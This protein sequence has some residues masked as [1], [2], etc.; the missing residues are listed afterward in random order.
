MAL[1]ELKNISKDYHVQKGFFSLKPGT[2]KAVDGVSIDV[3][4]GRTVGIVGESGCGKSTLAKMIVKLIAPTSGEIFFDGKAI[5][6]MPEKEFRVLRKKV[7]IVFQDPSNSLSPRFK[8]SRI[9]SEPLE[10]FKFEKKFIAKRV[11]ELIGEMGLGES[12]LNR[13]PYQLSGGERQRVGIARALATSA[14]LLILD[15]PVSS[16]DLSTQSQ[17]LNLLL[18]LQKDYGLTYLFIAHNLSVIRYISDTIMVMRR[19]NIVEI[20]ESDELYEKP[21]H[22]YTRILLE[23]APSLSKPISKKTFLL[24]TSSVVEADSFGCRF[25][26]RC[27]ARKDKCEK[28]KPQLREISKGH[29]VSCHHAA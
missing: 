13:R 1:L 2:I 17:V 14:K 19:G 27:P 8:I 10:A 15:E 18:K 12:Y 11:K 9:I 24:Q 21:A 4:E 23:S 3:Q 16:L 5:T 6:N 7:Q 25:F 28:I 26:Y 20:A 22:P 29:F